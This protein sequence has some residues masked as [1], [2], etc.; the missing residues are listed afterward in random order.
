[1]TVSIMSRTS[2]FTTGQGSA[3]PGERWRR[4]WTYRRILWLLVGRDL[5]VRY[6]RSALGYVWTVLEPLAMSFVYWFVFIKIVGRH[7]GFPPFIL[8]LIAGQLPWYWISGS[9]NGAVGALRGEAQMVRSS[10]VPREVWVLRVIMSRGAEYVFSLPVLALFALGYLKAPTADI[11]LLP[12]AMLMSIVLCMG[13]GMILA[14]AAV[15]VNDVRSIVR[16]AMRVLFYLSPI[17]YSIHDA[18]K[19]LGA[20]ATIQSWNPVAGIMVLYR[21]TFFP[22]EL[23]WS[24]VLH[25]AIVCILIFGIGLYTFNR[26]ERPMLKEI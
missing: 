19:R 26:L 11:V 4:V 25:S 10:N 3:G 15:L 22:Q 23:N 13:L 24:Y 9:I 17:L 14:P 1:M 8:F 7:I 16:I 12:L 5:Q 20:V 2:G 18:S 6:A 21:S